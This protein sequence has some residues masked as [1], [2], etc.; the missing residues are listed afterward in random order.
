VEIVPPAYPIYSFDEPNAFKCELAAKRNVE[1]DQLIGRRFWDCVAKF[2]VEKSFQEETIVIQSTVRFHPNFPLF[3]YA[4]S[5]R[6]I[7]DSQE[8]SPR[9]S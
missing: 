1:N 6:N 3:F 9:A 8:S 7:D 5:A 2:F 4:I